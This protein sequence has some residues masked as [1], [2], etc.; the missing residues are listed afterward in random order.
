M[1]L[2]VPSGVDHDD[3]ASADAVLAGHGARGDVI[4]D[5]RGVGGRVVL[6]AGGEG[7]GY[8]EGGD[9]RQDGRNVAHTGAERAVRL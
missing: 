8:D 3:E 7:E 9:S 2:A 1:V 5:A 4:G 6:A